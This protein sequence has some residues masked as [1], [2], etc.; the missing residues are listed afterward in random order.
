M[1]ERTLEVERKFTAP[2]GF[3]PDFTGL[4]EVL[5]T[6]VHELDATYHDTLACDLAD[7]GWSLRR[8][9]GGHDDGWHLKRPATGEGRVEVTAALSAD[10]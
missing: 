3:A 1:S 7:A 9:T 5:A 8:R 4:V 10:D 2:A 6:A